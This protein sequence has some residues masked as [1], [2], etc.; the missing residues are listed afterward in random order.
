MLLAF[1]TN[2]WLKSVK[3]PANSS[4]PGYIAGWN[5]TITWFYCWIRQQYVWLSYQPTIISLLDQPTMF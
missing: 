5:I 2:L 3:I 4:K 1:L